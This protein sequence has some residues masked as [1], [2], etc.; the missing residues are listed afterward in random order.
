MGNYVN[1]KLQLDFLLRKVLIVAGE[2]VICLLMQSNRWKMLR[3]TRG[4]RRVLQR[5]MPPFLVELK[6]PK[7]RGILSSRLHQGASRRT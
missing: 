1:V 3:V 6:Q 2:I 4:G 5:S 7:T